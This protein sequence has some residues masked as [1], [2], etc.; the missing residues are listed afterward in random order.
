MQKNRLSALLN[1]L[2][3]ES[4]RLGKLDFHRSWVLPFK[5]HHCLRDSSIKS[6]A[7]LKQPAARRDVYE[8][9]SFDRLLT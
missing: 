9:A 1:S 3:R 7:C 4:H 2:V 8:F 6:Q 5:R